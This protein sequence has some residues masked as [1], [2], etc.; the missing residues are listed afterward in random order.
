MTPVTY[1]F[2]PFA[3]EA[4]ERRL[5]RDGRTVAITPKSFDLLCL[6]VENE[7]HVLSKTEILQRLWTESFVDESNLR[8]NV[9]TLRRLLAAGGAGD[10]IETVPRYGYRWKGQT[11]ARDTHPVAGPI[12][13]TFYARSGDVNIAYQTVGDGVVDVVFV[14]GWVSHLEYF[15]REPRFAA[16]LGAL[17]SQSRLILFDK[18]GTGLSDRV[19]ID[20]LPTLEERMD[21]LRAVMDA[22]GSRRAVL[23]GVSEGGPLCAL[24][25]A[26][27]PDRTQAV[28]MIGTYARR[29]RA[30]D[31]PIGT[32]PEAHRQ[33]LDLIRA[34]WGG[35]VGIETR[36]PSLAGDTAFRDWWASYLRMGASPSAAVAL[37]RMNAEIDIRPILPSVRVPSLVLHRTGDRCLSVEEGRYVAEL[38]PGS[39]FMELPGDDHL[40]FVGRQE[41]ILD[42]VLSFLREV[43]GAPDAERL[44][45]TIL[46]VRFSAIPDARAAEEVRAVAHRHRG[47]SVETRQTNATV[48]AFLFDGPAR[49]I[50]GGRDI[51][52]VANA[53]GLIASAAVHTGECDAPTGHQL[54]GSAPEIAHRVLDLAADGEVVASRTVKDLVAG[55]ELE[56]EQ[57]DGRAVPAAD[58]EWALFRVRAPLAAAASA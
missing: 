27:Y 54:H 29:L 50:R 43:A 53:H 41:E 45:V 20:R 1:H 8:Q 21:D 46:L 52:G 7:G 19:P 30:A 57:A 18:R 56:F 34:N 28:V 32:D 26:T 25:A 3:L 6:L 58:G 49:A 44:L 51:H 55:S 14:M 31:Y 4:S 42:P 5:T 12:P 48:T 33:F 13:E 39:R 24:F 40:P 23:V 10:L 9:S 17:A 36:A 16:F 47:R 2:G 22:A 37:T 11:T 15:W 35:P 38:I